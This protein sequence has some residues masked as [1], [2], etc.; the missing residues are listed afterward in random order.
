[1]SSNFFD[2]PWDSDKKHSSA[3]KESV[4]EDTKSSHKD[5]EIKK[6]DKQPYG[7]Y[8]FS[9]KFVLFILIICLFGWLATG[10]FTINPDEVGIILRFGKYSRTAEP[11]LNYK[12][13]EPVE[14]LSK[15]S[16]TRL[17]KEFIGERG[18]KDHAQYIDVGS[19]ESS[20]EEGQMLTG[21]ENIIDLSFF[22]QWR[23]SNPVYYLFNIKDERAENTV[24]A[25]AESSMR[26]VIGLAK[27]NEALSEQRQGIEAKATKILQDTLDLYKAGVQVTNLGILYSYVAPEVRDAYRDVQSSKADRE[28]EI[29]KALTYENDII[30]KARGEAKA[31][32]EEAQAYS[33]SLILRAQGEA[34]RFNSI[35][36]QYQV[37]KNVTRKRMYI[38]SMESILK[39]MNKIIINNQQGG[40]LPILSLND[41]LKIDNK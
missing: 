14:T 40:P 20:S 25:T 34:D 24:R 31:L 33:Q 5:Q 30:P 41:A 38:E 1:M 12:I 28:R 3:K 19:K 26:Q 2:N 16:V 4:G 9:G 35:L 27:L 23:I 17:H 39:G 21:D 22:V 8:F 29:N 10:F 15:V 18:Q 6:N 13:P 11:G 37:S 36:S 7:G 32:L